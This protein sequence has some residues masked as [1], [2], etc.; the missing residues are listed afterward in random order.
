MNRLKFTLPFSFGKGLIAKKSIRLLLEVAGSVFALFVLILLVLLG[1]LSMGPINLDFLTPHVEAAL[2][3]PTN[4]FKTSIHHT[5][6]VWREWKRPFEVELVDVHFQKDAKPDWLNIEHVGISLYFYRLLGGDVALK[7]MRL[8]RPH[9]LLER[10]AQ[11]KFSLGLGDDTS[12]HDFSFE[13]ISS[14]LALGAV[15]PALGKLNDLKKISI[16]DANVVLKDDQAGQQWE[17][18]KA[19]FVLRRG[20]G[21]FRTDLTL[22]PLQGQGLLAL[23]LSHALGEPRVDVTANF[24]QVALKS[25]IEKDRPTLG[26]LNPDVI[27]PDDILNLFQHWDVPLNGNVHLSL[28]PS[29][30]EVIEGSCDVDF[31]KGDLDLSLA[32]LR[33]L[34]L[35]AGNLS[36]AL[37]PEGIDLKNA[38][39]LSEEMLLQLSGKISSRGGPLVLTKLLGPD[40]TLDIQGKIEDLSLD[41]LAALWP[42]SLAS[43]PREWLTENLRTG[44]ITEATLS[45]KGHGEETGFVVDDL[46]G[47]ILG[48]GAEITYLKG[49]PVA[50]DIKVAAT[51]DSRGFDIKLLSGN[52]ETFQ[53]Q[54]GRIVISGLDV[55]KEKLALD[56]KGKGPLSDVLDIINHKPLEYASYGGIDPKKTKGSGS[57]NLHMDF[58]LLADLRFKDIKMTLKGAFKGVEL[59]RK[60][61]DKF[62]AQLREGA[63]SIDLTQDQMKIQGTGV[64]NQLSSSLLY[65]HYFTASSPHQLQLQIETMAS[66]A[67]FKRLGFGYEEYGR[68]P[69]RAKL[70]Y[71]FEKDKKSHFFVDLDITRAILDF[72]PL[73]W[74]KKPGEAGNLSFSLLFEGGHLAKM[75]ELKM[76]TPVYSFQGEIVFDPQQAWKTIHLSELKG[77]HTHTQVTLKN[78]RKDAYEVSFKGQSV[79][80]EKFLAY[81]DQEGTAKE[82]P[83]TDIKLFAEVGQLRLGEGRVFQNVQAAADLFLQGTETLWKE[84]T[85]RAKAGEGMADKGDVA[86]VSGGMLF[87]LKPG[88]NNTQTLLVRANDAGQF[89]RNLSIY[90]DVQ[91]G[92]LTIKAERQNHGPYKGVFKLKEFD[93]HKI[94]LLARF[95]GILSPIGII[96]LFSAHEN[97]SME[98]FDCDFVFDDSFVVLKNGIG[99]SVSLG[100]TVEGKLDRRNR[101]Y[102]LKGNLIPA[103][104]LNSI[105]NNIPILGPLLSGGEG[106]GLFAMSYT[107]T[108]PFDKPDIAAN[109]L[110]MFAPGFL[111][112]LFSPD[113]EGK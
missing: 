62:T 9:I 74:E 31:G 6:L 84:V 81:V 40:K 36:F 30:F 37:S 111:R 48:E 76:R 73:G 3:T 87:D 14:F 75:T 102:A 77:P 17:L 29:T 22:T 11:G 85:L 21:G 1:R 113:E 104:F 2:Q 93:A 110:S 28:V 64:L 5:Q 66:F 32:N 53:L 105:L 99:K 4:D 24:Q 13:E 61:T 65:T 35:V 45:L 88:P 58:P 10:N 98:R 112:N 12:D 51:F 23:N 70:T 79:D 49:L 94:P 33:P 20:S 86:H 50:K 69:T 18:P 59:D 92:Q 52:I 54:E 57:I 16:V 41:H 107:V 8:Y 42:Q 63:L 7:H 43:A 60:V 80:L 26:D 67:D 108:G 72:P 44:L 83:L 101:T 106:E 68:G 46:T 91:G 56:I 95:A 47:T 38:S 103:R 55:G 96:N 15:N 71:T 78:P 34:P 39:L 97:V 100:F 89:L 27:T 109:P 90:D 19:T 25:L 82:Y